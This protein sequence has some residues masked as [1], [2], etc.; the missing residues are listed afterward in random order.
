MW[1]LL[2]FYGLSEF[3]QNLPDDEWYEMKLRI[4][5]MPGETAEVYLVPK[6]ENVNT[7]RVL[8]VPLFKGRP[9]TKQ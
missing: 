8:N 4:R 5:K 9:K 1:K 6:I 2:R 7:G 3:A